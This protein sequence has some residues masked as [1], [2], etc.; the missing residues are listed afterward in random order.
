MTELYLV[1]HSYLQ[2][3]ALNQIKK[4]INWKS[5]QNIAFGQIRFEL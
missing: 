1:S 3:H 4:C 2:L 5:W